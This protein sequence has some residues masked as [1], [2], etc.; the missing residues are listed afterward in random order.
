[1]INNKRHFKLTGSLNIFTIQ[2]K[3]FYWKII[4]VP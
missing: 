2:Q 4:I 3:R 1:M